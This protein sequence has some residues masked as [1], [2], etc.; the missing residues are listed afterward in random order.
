MAVLGYRRVG[1]PLRFRCP[2]ALTTTVN[3][4][5]PILSDPLLDALLGARLHDPFAF[6]GVHRL[7]GEWILRV[8]NPHA[9]ALWLHLHGASVPLERT[10]PAGLFE[11]RGSMRPPEAYLLGAQEDGR[12]RSFHDPYAF[13]P[14]LSGHDLYLF[15]E[16]R[17]RQAWRALGSHVEE[18]SGV[19]GTRFAVWAPN[20][21][22]VSVVGDFNRW[23][24]RLHPMAAHGGSGVWELFV[25]GLADGELYKFEIRNQ[26]SGEV[27]VKTDPFAQHFERRPGTAARV[28]HAG[29]Y[30]WGD[31]A[32]MRRR[33]QWDWQHAPLSIYEVHLGSWRR[34]PD[35][36]FY[37]YR[38]LAAHLVPYVKDMGYTHVELLPLTEHPLDESWG[39]Q[40]TG[41]FAATARFGT[42]DELRG[43][44]DAFHQA[45][46][47]VILDWV[48]A[49]F[50][51]DQWA[52][53]RFD[54]TALYEHE[55]PRKG[56]H[57][58]WGTHIF[59][60][61][62]NE[63]VS[64]L[65]SSAHF[66]LSQ[67]HADGLR[68]D[69]V[70]SMLYLDYSRKPGEWLPNK[71]GGRENLEA[72]EFVRQLNVMVHEEFP[73]AITL[74]EESTAWP[75]V[76]RPAYLGGLG[77]TMKWNMGWMNDTLS[78]MH[79]DPIYRRYHHD[80]LTFGQLYA[81]TE[82]FL[83]P[84]SHDEVVHG[85]GSLL[86]KMPGET[87]HEF[88][89]LRLLLLCQFATPGK[90]LNFMGNELAQGREWQSRWE[91][92]WGLLEIDWHAG[93]QRLMR[94]LNRL[95][96]DNRALHEQDFTQEGF[97]WIDCHDADHSTL[98]FVRRARDGACVVVVLSF[99]PVAHHGYRIGL[100]HAGR[101]AEIMNSDSAYYGGSNAG[102]AGLVEA[103]P[104][105]WMGF[106]HSAAI[107]VPPLAGIILEP[108]G[109]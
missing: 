104:L 32:W 25:P 88:A 60:Y 109:C 78:Y 9:E 56:L 105:P 77:F 57:V 81:Y 101:Y 94:D 31:E 26:A 47:G 63:V 30:Q 1:G 11:W 99:T 14:A 39:Y 100:P 55:D 95:H 41:Y 92:D 107:T 17:L 22:R 43:L 7:G 33:A 61:G 72:I 35:G 54:G 70:A 42:P 103:E 62:R 64:F 97:S 44:I 38:E 73:G 98:S 76:S 36:R 80:K 102:N 85:K 79:L 84:L 49:H 51:Q 27:L 3:S 96:R 52:L 46:V 29:R 28:Y 68:V 21:E 83:L 59:N 19:I 106:G 4:G 58:D 65:L 18:R 6:L 45:G 48:P 71:H 108:R 66:W 93:V 10:H 89:N 40:T 12:S 86:D 67:F 24:G 16:G 8:F 53:A 50:P 2:S 87:A 82:N 20:A 75:M 37:S 90:K 34:H 5:A 13:V 23:D 91:L 15:N 74:A 69:A